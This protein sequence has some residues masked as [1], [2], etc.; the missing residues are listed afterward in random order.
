MYYHYN[1]Y[2]NMFEKNRRKFTK[3]RAFVLVSKTVR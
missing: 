3:N 1:L 2:K